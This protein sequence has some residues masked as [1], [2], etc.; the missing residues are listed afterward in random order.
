MR[1]KGPIRICID[2]RL[3]NGVRGGVQ[4]FIIGLASGL[5]QLTDGD[6]EYLF[7]TYA[8]AD[9]WLLPYIDG[10]KS[11]LRVRRS[12]LKWKS[13][14]KSMA[15]GIR[16]LWHSVSPL[17]GRWVSRIPNSDGTVERAGVDIVHF[18]KQD[19]FLTAVPSVYHP[20]DL[21]HVHFPE[22]F[23]P[24]NVRWRELTYRCLCDQARMVATASNWGKTDL[25]HYYQLPEAKVRIVPIAP[26][27][28]AYP[29]PSANDIAEVRLRFSLPKGFIFYPAQTWRHKNHLTLLEALSMLRQKTGLTIP[30]VCSGMLVEF[31]PHIEKK[32]RE[33]G[34]ADQ[35]QFLGFVSP[36]E[37]QCLYRLG[38]V[39][40]FPSLYEGGGLPILEGFLA[41]MPVACSN[42]TCLPEQAGDA[43]MIFDPTKPEEIAAAIIQLWTDEGLRRAFIK[44]GKKRA[45]AFTLERTAR[46]C[47]AHYRRI[48]GLALNE[49]DRILVFSAPA[50]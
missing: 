36:F 48:A 16:Q 4:Q 22:F 7:L 32:A 21:Q 23:S 20:W 26:V 31:F 1:K 3:E 14:L 5:S 38:R 41:G 6:E 42:A 30:L 24:H 50:T 28:T 45:G 12:Q 13:R 18:P 15:P 9:G 8:D 2:A 10:P 47:R 44:R 40:I 34:I 11:L 29:Q 39:L 25:M 43:A 49:E 19:G 33:L 27:L 37:L 17:F 46:I 35:V